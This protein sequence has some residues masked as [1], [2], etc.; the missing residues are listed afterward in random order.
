VK[1][2]GTGQDIAIAADGS[3]VVGGNTDSAAVFGSEP[4]TSVGYANAF[5][6]VLESNGT[7]RWAK[8]FGSSQYS[9]TLAIAAAP[10]NFVY[11][12]GWYAKDF[13][14]GVEV[15]TGPSELDE[16]GFLLRIAPP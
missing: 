9:F 4:V 3:I 13:D 1:G 16:E 14:N 15:W 5:V 7:P 11:A 10:N 6:A 12:A 2:L 8:M